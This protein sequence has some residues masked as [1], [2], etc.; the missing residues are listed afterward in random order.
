M[1]NQFSPFIL[2][3]RVNQDVEAFRKRW[4]ARLPGMTVAL[5]RKG[6]VV[7]AQGYGVANA[8]TMAPMGA[9]TRS[10]FGSIA[11]A[12][13]TGF[14]GHLVLTDQKPAIDPKTTPLYGQKGLFK[15]EF[16]DDLAIGAKRHAPII[17]VSIDPD[18]RVHA[19][20]VDGKVSVGRTDDLAALTAPT[21]FELPEGKEIRDICGIAFSKN[22]RVLTFYTNGTISIG[23][24]TKLDAEGWVTTKDSKTEKAVWKTAK[25]DKYNRQPVVAIVGIDMSKSDNDIYTWYA[26]GTVGR[27]RLEDLGSDT[28]CEKITCAKRPG[29]SAQEIRGVAI[30]ADDTVYTWF[31]ND[32]V[33]AGNSLKLDAH[34]PPYAYLT[35][36]IDAKH[37]RAAWFA[38]ITLQNLLDH[39][40]GFANLVNIEEIARNHGKPTSELTYKEVHQY[41]LRNNKLLW[42]PEAKTSRYSNHGMGMWTLIVERLTGKKFRQVV[43]ERYLEPF[44]LADLIDSRLDPRIGSVASQHRIRADK[45]V[46]HIF[47][48]EEIELAAGG[49]RASARGLVIATLK[50]LEHLV[51]LKELAK[52][53][54]DSEDDVVFHGGSGA[55][56]AF[57]RMYP[58]GHQLDGA[59]VGEVHGAVVI[60][61]RNNER[62]DGADED[63]DK[64]EM[65]SDMRLL[66]RKLV[67][68]VNSA[69][70]PVA[71]MRLRYR[72]WGLAEELSLCEGQLEQDS[73]LNPDSPGLAVLKAK[74][75]GLQKDLKAARDEALAKHYLVGEPPKQPIDGD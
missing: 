47:P 68:L 20:Y 8:T 53:G 19:W 52:N 37:D 27:W 28:T 14:T 5:S 50:Q 25:L 69:T 12:A 2:L 39:T 65:Y 71:A 18:D 22:G 35:P 38:K 33:S 1:S 9:N 30:S 23:T 64:D 42:S 58:P 34:K 4:G 6:Q 60:N 66:S 26:D 67:T 13:V 17:D 62:E 72:I 54:W 75:T 29:G 40:A 48:I 11:K 24:A 74:I 32:T 21:P 63:E 45:A 44:G 57:V 49:Y 7:L 41:F 43:R 10:G 55:G 56:I 16:D 15:G 59:D 73:K 31:G 70:E 3:Q 46:P 51:D 61:V 36:K